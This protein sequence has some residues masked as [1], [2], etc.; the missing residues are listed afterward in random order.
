MQIG[1]TQIKPLP[2]VQIHLL[3]VCWIAR[4]LGGGEQPFD[5]GTV[6]LDASV[7]VAVGADAVLDIWRHRPAFGEIGPALRIN[8]GFGTP[9]QALPRPVGVP[10]AAVVVGGTLGLVTH[11]SAPFAGVGGA[12]RSRFP[13]WY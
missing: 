11:S 2:N 3:R 12:G 8:L 10:G 13:N 7:F 6:E 1:A 5:I 4:T 9:G